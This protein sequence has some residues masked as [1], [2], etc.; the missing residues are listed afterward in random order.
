DDLRSSYDQAARGAVVSLPPKT[1]S[2]KEWSERLDRRAQAADLA[3]EAEYWLSRPWNHAAR[4]PTDRP[5]GANLAASA[6]N[7]VTVLS[8]EQTR[9]LLHDLPRLHD[10]GV[11]V[12]L[13]FT[14]ARS[15][16]RWT[17]ARAA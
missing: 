16:S 1:T 8:P 12:L 13:L 15:L 10:V 3:Q 9:A 7:V 2:F 11:D 14:L 4:L 17:A 5:G 6:R